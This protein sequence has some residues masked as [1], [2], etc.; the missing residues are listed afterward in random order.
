MRIWMAAVLL[1][2]ACASTGG[3]IPKDVRGVEWRAVEIGGRGVLPD[4][5]VTLILGPD[6]RASGRSSCNSYSGQYETRR[7]DRISFEGLGGT[8]MAC[9]SP[10]MAQE[11]AY[12]D[13]L[14]HVESFAYWPGNMLQLKTGEGRTITFRRQ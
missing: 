5:P 8:E 4:A 3:G 14:R 12:L 11:G 2:P 1:A 7:P 10:V 6:G 13:M 9:A